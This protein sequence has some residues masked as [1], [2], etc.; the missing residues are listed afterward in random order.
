MGIELRAVGEDVEAA[1]VGVAGVMRQVAQLAH[2][3][4][5]R[6]GAEGSHELRERGDGLAAQQ[7]DEGVGGVLGGLIMSQ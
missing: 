5:L 6:V 4:A 1:V 3:S 2:G 7:I